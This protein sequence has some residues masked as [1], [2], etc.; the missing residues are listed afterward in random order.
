[1]E[2]SRRILMT[3]AAK[4]REEDGESLLDVEFDLPEAWVAGRVGLSLAELK[5]RRGPEGVLWKKTA[6]G[7][8]M[9]SAAGVVR[10]EAD[11]A[12]ER[13]AE[14]GPEKIPA[15]DREA[16]LVARVRNARALH[17]VRD[18][19]A[20]DPSRPRVVWLPRPLGRLFR[21][22]MRVLARPRPRKPWVWDYEGNPE[23]PSGGRRF[24]RRVGQW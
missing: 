22:G 8:V 21:P 24:P 20:Y 18:G 16:F 9:W 6:H 15:A 5:S 10:L 4:E 14:A 1:M 17:V 3:K 7:R 13:G 12:Q 11:L 2:N 23:S 19:E